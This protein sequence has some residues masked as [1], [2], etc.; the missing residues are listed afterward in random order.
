[1]EQQIRALKDKVNAQEKEI[2]VLK[3]SL[4]WA[5]RYFKE[6]DPEFYELMWGNDE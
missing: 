2:L 3:K 4:Q 5:Q 1:M 6:Y